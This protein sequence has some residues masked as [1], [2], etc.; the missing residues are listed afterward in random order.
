MYKYLHDYVMNGLVI[1]SSRGRVTVPVVSG[2]GAAVGIVGLRKLL[3]MLLTSLAGGVFD[4]R[5]KRHFRGCCRCGSAFDG[6]NRND[7]VVFSYLTFVQRLL[8]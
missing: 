8:C 5:F 1:R 3:T 2:R 4:I 6:I 7:A